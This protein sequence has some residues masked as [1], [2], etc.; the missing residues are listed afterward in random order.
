MDQWKLPAAKGDNRNW[1][2]ALSQRAIGWIFYLAIF[3][4]NDVEA[5]EQDVNQ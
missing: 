4:Y 2:V 1:V 5:C 3:Y